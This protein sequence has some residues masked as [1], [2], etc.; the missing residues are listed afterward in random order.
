MIYYYRE[1]RCADGVSLGF[2]VNISLLRMGHD[3]ANVV[4][5]VTHCSVV[6]HSLFRRHSVFSAAGS[7]G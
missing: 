3:L 6:I 1:P 5:I 2:A 7:F 4:G